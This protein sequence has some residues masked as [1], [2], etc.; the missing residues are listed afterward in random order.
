MTNIFSISRQGVQT[1][2]VQNLNGHRAGA[3]CYLTDFVNL[4]IIVDI[5]NGD[6]SFD[7]TKPIK[8]DADPS[9]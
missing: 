6:D 4:K 8:Y 3:K 7:S 2:G 9:F 1:A 5:I